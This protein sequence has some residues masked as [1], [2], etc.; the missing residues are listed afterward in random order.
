M[1]L[2]LEINA[3]EC[4]FVSFRCDS[5]WRRLRVFLAKAHHK[6]KNKKRTRRDCFFPWKLYIDIKSM[7]DVRE[8]IVVCRNG[9]KRNEEEIEINST[10]ERTMF[11]M[12]NEWNGGKWQRNNRFSVHFV[13]ARV[14]V[15]A[16]QVPLELD[17][18]HLP[19]IVAVPHANNANDKRLNSKMKKRRKSDMQMNK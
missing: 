12:S 7:N 2:E 3:I 10:G 6:I 8:C 14:C 4:T 9:K 17:G 19:S 13:R 11:W 16:N 18:F 1:C 5:E 15:C